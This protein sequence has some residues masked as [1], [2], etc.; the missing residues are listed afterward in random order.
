MEIAEAIPEG[1][2]R[3]SAHPKEESQQAER[4][5]AMH[6]P[7]RQGCNYRFRTTNVTRI[8]LRAAAESASKREL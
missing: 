1:N 6:Q 4:R 8:S 3:L 7:E 2:V 5:R